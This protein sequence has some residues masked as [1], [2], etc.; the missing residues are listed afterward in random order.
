MKRVI[1]PAAVAAAVLAL[2]APGRASEQPCLK[3]EPLQASAAAVQLQP[4]TPPCA[5]ADRP[6]AD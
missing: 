5:P 2:A 1:V 3:G 4:C 6:C